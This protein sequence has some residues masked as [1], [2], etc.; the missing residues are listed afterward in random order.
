MSAALPG[1]TRTLPLVSASPDRLRFGVAGCQNYEDGYF[2]AYGH[3][4]REDDLAFVYHYGDY[5]YE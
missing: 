1:G 4:A 3:L 2:T 5:I